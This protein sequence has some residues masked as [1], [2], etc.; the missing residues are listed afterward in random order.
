MSRIS[1]HSGPVGARKASKLRLRYACQLA[2][3]F[4]ATLHILHAAENPYGAYG[5]YI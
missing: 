4:D 1:D 2:D 5:G 3:A